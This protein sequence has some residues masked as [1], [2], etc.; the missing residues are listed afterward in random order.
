MCICP[1]ASREIQQ[2]PHMALRNVLVELDMTAGPGRFWTQPFFFDPPFGLAPH[3]LTF[4][5]GLCSYLLSI[6]C[7]YF[8]QCSSLPHP[9]ALKVKPIETPRC[10]LMEFLREDRRELLLAD[11]KPWFAVRSLILH[12]VQTQQRSLACLHAHEF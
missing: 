10:T 9:A 8:P 7:I 1:R 11:T 5:T 4:T 3:C 6:L 12:R 2:G